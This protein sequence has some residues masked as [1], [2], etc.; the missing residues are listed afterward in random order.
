MVYNRG[1]KPKAKDRLVL[2]LLYSVFPSNRS[3]KIPPLNF[4][5]LNNKNLYKKK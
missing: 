5:E 3:P 1:V 2:S 4:S